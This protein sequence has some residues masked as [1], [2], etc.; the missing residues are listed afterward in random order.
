[1]FE[2]L[3]VMKGVLVKGDKI[4]VPKELQATVIELSHETHG[5]GEMKTLQF[6]RESMWFPQMGKMTKDFVS[7][8]RECAAAVPGNP[9]APIETH[10]MREKAWEVVVADFKGPRRGGKLLLPHND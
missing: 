4:V 7:S 9:P 6:L 1:M 5:L 3:S 10:L 2:E 8:C